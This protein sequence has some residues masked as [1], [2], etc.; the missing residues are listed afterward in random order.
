MGRQSAAPHR[1]Q[2]I[3]SGELIRWWKAIPVP[4]GTAGA[5][6]D[7]VLFIEQEI[8]ETARFLISNTTTDYE[9][10]EFG[11]IRQGTLQISAFPDWARFNKGDRVVLLGAGR[12]QSSRATLTRGSGTEDDLIYTPVKSITAVYIAG[13]EVDELFYEAT[14]TTIKWMHGEPV[15]LITDLRNIAANAREDGQMRKAT[16]IN[17]WFR[18]DQDSVLEDNGTTVI[19]PTD[20]AA[21]D[22]GRWLNVQL[23]GEEPP[24]E[25]DQ[26]VVEYEFYPRYIVKPNRE[27]T[28]PTDKNG[29]SLPLLYWLELELRTGDDEILE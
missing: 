26:Y 27:R 23:T 7:G 19:K 18:F 2:H 24:E 16:G 25:D 21:E 28:S 13:D 22:E 1:D 14:D 15:A 4:P 6:R 29:V 3:A 20:I 5:S 9:S 17:P 8:D 12:V 10:K 11:L